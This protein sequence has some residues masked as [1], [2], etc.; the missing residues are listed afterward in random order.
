MLI[1]NEIPDL[2]FHIGEK[3]ISQPVVAGPFGVTKFQY[4]SERGFF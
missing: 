3:K 4:I 2:Y 1:D